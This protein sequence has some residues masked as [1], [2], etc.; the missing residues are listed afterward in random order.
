MHVIGQDHPRIHHK[1]PLR[2]RHPHRLAQPV[3]LPSKQIAPPLRQ[4]DGQEHTGTGHFGAN[5]G[6][7]PGTLTAKP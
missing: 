3:H 7:H 2:P 4:A 6:R 5:I 1:R